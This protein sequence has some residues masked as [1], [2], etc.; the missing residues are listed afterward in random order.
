MGAGDVAEI[1][2]TTKKILGEVARN[3]IFKIF[4]ELIG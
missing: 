1:Q 2:T 4:D 3:R